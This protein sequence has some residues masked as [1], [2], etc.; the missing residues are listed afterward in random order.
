M[1]ENSAAATTLARASARRLP[2][3][4]LPERCRY[5]FTAPVIDET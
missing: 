3:I 5:S 1:S 2:L 4:G